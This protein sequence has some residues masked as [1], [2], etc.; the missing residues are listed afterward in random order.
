[1]GYWCVSKWGIQILKDHLNWKTQCLTIEYILGFCLFLDKAK[2]PLFDVTW[3]SASD[4]SENWLAGKRK[5]EKPRCSLGPNHWG[6]FIAPT[7]MDWFTGK[8]YTKP[9][10]ISTWSVWGFPAVNQHDCVVRKIKFWHTQLFG[11]CAFYCSPK[12]PSH[13]QKKKQNNQ[14][15]ASQD[16]E[17]PGACAMLCQPRL[18]ACRVAMTGSSKVVLPQL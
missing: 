2:Y 12:K 4:H 8:T 18:R 5:K 11:D 10:G 16:A 6:Q 1:M 7:T 14:P 17:E 13:R 3:Q 9:R 15:P